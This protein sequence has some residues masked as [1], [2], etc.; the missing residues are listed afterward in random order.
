MNQGTGR[1]V[2]PLIPALLIAAS[3]ASVL[4][5]DLYAPSLPHLPALLSTD[6]ATVTLTMSLNVG[7]FALALALGNARLQMPLGYFLLGIA[8]WS[9]RLWCLT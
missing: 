9:F 8:I 1:A 3:S 4:S 5:T 7:S 6:A 2:S